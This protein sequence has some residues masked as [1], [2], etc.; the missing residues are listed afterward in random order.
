MIDLKSVDPTLISAGLAS[1]EATLNQLIKMDTQVQHKLAALE[2]KSLLVKVTQPEFSLCIHIEN[3]Q[4]ALTHRAR[5]EA[6]ACLQGSL[7]QFLLLIKADNKSNALINGELMLTGD[8]LFVIGFSEC[9]ADV[10]PDWEA[11]LAKATGDTLAHGFGRLTRRGLNWGKQ[12]FNSING[13]LAEY[14]QEETSMV[15]SQAEADAQYQRVDKLSMD[16]E[17]LQARIDRLQ[18]SIEKAK[19]T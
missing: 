8:T 10:A 7:Q 14:L 6:S 13:S 16:T 3:K 2:G 17:R 11:L 12:S 4:M 18:R 5:G 9:L 1:A 19:R 15:P